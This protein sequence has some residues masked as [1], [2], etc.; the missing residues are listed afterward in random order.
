MDGEGEEV[1]PLEPKTREEAIARMRAEL[2][3]AAVES[4]MNESEAEAFVDKAW[5]LMNHPGRWVV[6]DGER[7]WLE[8]GEFLVEE[9]EDALYPTE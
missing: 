5:E 7:I 1:M 2:T 3:R 9:I 6:W 8:R 4:G